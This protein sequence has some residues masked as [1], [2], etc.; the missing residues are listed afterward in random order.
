MVSCTQYLEVL[1]A[2]P[3]DPGLRGGKSLRRLLSLGHRVPPDFVS[4]RDAFRPLGSR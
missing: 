1:G 2:G 4:A 3:A